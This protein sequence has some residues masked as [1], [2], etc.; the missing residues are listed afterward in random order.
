[1][2]IGILTSGGDA[3]GMNAAIRAV[4]RGA[5]Y[6]DMEVV[7]IHNG[8]DGILHRETEEMDLSSV[9]DIIH[10][11]GTVLGTGRSEAMMTEEG[12]EQARENLKAMGIDH[13]IVI[14]GNG[15]MAGAL[16]LSKRG[17]SAV[18]IPAT[19]D[20]D[21]GYQQASI[22]FYTAIETI[23]D[24]IGKIR[25]TSSSHR[26]ANIVEVMGRKCGDLALCAG[27][28]GGAESI[29]VPELPMDVARIKNKVLSGKAR[30][31]RHHIILVTEGLISPY[32]LAEDVEAST[33][34]ET[35]VTVLGYLQRG[36]SPSVADRINASRLGTAAVRACADGP[37]SIALGMKKGDVLS[38][39]LAEALEIEKT[40]DRALYDTLDK[41]SI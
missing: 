32:A 10:R 1:M 27:I 38:M 20:N 3:P 23:T 7:G 16:A 4:V 41:I 6:E 35:R 18:C 19:I 30:G 11:G 40:F 5:R 13:L 37:V 26:R 28:A 17:Q 15:S 14:G 21:L 31:K 33:G 9:A 2:R 22:G 34:V 29:L 12:Q 8:F 24:A 36:G 25:D 39:D